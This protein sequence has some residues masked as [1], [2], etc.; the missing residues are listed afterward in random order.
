MA[1]L[2]DIVFDCSHPAATARFWAAALDG[3][4]VAPYDD[5]EL[6]RLRSLGITS[7]EDDPTVLVEPP[8]GGP[9]LW[10]QLVPEAKRVKN[11]VHLDL[12][13]VD[14]EAEIQ[15]LAALGATVQARHPD[16]VVLADPEGNEFC[17]SLRP[18]S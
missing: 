10:F 5:E 11:R 15:R 2:G 13:A 1:R 3:Y 6:A 8:E 7:S 16:N 4:A 14:P 12:L 9:R 18:A 17:L